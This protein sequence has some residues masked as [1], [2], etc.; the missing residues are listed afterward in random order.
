MQL[1]FI[2]GNLGC[3]VFLEKLQSHLRDMIQRFYVSEVLKSVQNRS[4]FLYFNTSVTR[5]Y[6]I[7]SRSG[8]VPHVRVLLWGQ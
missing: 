2:C 1:I 6:H 5:I 4:K 3:F 8:D 7:V